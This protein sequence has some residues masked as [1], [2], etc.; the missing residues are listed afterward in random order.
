[1]RKI[2]MYWLVLVVMIVSV[3][4]AQELEEVGDDSPGVYFEF[5]VGFSTS[6]LWR[7]IDYL[8]GSE[9]SV[10]TFRPTINPSITFATD[11]GVYLNL[12]A[13]VALSERSNSDFATGDLDE[14][15]VTLGYAAGGKY[16]EIDAGIAYYGYLIGYGVSDDGAFLNGGIG[17]D[18][19]LYLSYTAPVLLSPKVFVAV[20]EETT[21]YNSYS[22]AYDFSFFDIV[23]FS[24]SALVGIWFP[25]RT[26]RTNVDPAFNNRIWAHFDILVPVSL[27]IYQ[28]L[29]VSADFISSFRVFP[30]GVSS[31]LDAPLWYGAINIGVSYS[32]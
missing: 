6:Y 27:D 32:L 7:G 23:T 10:F 4:N 11:I 1:M 29:V 5:S 25:S 2:F 15:D 30:G 17:P 21:F 12:W 19:E 9:N 13:S 24:P 18:L 22:I 26:A 16:G 31:Q 20:D 3:V 28:G 14:I 8:A